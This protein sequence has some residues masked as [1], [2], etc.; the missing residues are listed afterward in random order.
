MLLRD[1]HSPLRSCAE[2]ARKNAIGALLCRAAT[3][4]KTI[5]QKMG[6]GQ[7]SIA[8]F[9]GLKHDM[10]EPLAVALATSCEGR[11]ADADNWHLALVRDEAAIEVTTRDFL[12]G[13]AQGH[14]LWF[15]CPRKGCG[16]ITDINRDKGW[17][18]L[19]AMDMLPVTQISLGP[20]RSALRFRYRDQIRA[21]TRR[22]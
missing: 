14:H 3:A 22:F 6:F 5:L 13:Y 8:G 15:A 9:A 1:E 21:M 11:K 4:E 12:S 17:Q 19:A 18:P 2:G 7:G 10:A 16:I 20:L